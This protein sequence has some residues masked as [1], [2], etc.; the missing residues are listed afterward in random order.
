MT[1]Y[2]IEMG[3]WKINLTLND[4]ELRIDCDSIYERYSLHQ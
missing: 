3:G 1:E 4:I 2:S